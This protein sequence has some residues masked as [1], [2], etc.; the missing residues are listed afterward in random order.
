VV[1]TSS[2]MRGRSRL[3][4]TSLTTTLEQSLALYEGG[5]PE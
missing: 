5:D 2:S 4:E 3:E 1:G